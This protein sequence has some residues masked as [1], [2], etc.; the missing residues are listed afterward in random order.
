MDENFV[1]V[2][3]RIQS[4]LDDLGL[5]QVNVLEKTGL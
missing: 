2:G 5:K 4:K 3:D 1:G